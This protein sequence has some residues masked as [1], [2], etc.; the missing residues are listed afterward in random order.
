MQLHRPCF[1][2][3]I[4]LHTNQSI[5]R[6]RSGVSPGYRANVH[7]IRPPLHPA[8]LMCGRARGQANIVGTSPST[9]TIS[10]RWIGLPTQP[11]S[12]TLQLHALF[13]VCLFVFQTN[14]TFV[15]LPPPTLKKKKKKN[16]SEN[17]CC[18]YLKGLW[19]NEFPGPTFHK[20]EGVSF[21]IWT[22]YCMFKGLGGNRH[23]NGKVWILGE[24]FWHMLNM[25][26]N[27]SFNILVFS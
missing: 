20:Q 9:H 13:V 1:T 4:I 19:Y 5:G 12:S 14:A 22:G 18:V 15:S 11:A 7:K 2:C 25:L 21:I 3:C 17:S 24:W 26:F 8:G 10:D 16:H 27:W 23:V 6:L